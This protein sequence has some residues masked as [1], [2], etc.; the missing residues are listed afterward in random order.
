MTALAL[1]ALIIFVVVWQRT[2]ILYA[3]GC[4]VALVYGLRVTI[5]D[6]VYS[7]LWVAGVGVAS[8]GVYFLY[9]I[10]AEGMGWKIK[11]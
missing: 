9:C 5:I 11:R 1:T 8:I 2:I 10:I 3:I 6:D 4:P 7:S